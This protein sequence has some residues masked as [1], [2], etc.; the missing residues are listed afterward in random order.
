MNDEEGDVL[1]QDDIDSL[2]HQSESPTGLLGKI[3]RSDGTCTRD[4][5]DIKIE[6]YDFRNPVF[7]TEN[8]LRQIRIRHEK[9]IHFLVARMSLF[10]RMDFNMKMSKLYTTSYQKFTEKMPNPTHI[11]LFKLSKL[12]GI[13]IFNVSPRLA[14]T[15][16]N[17]M[18]GGSGHSV[19]DERYLTEIEATLVD[20]IASIVL[21]EWTKQWEGYQQLD[22]SLVGRENN[23]RF[24]QTSPQDAVMLVVDVEA[25]IGDCMEQFQIAVPY[26]MIEPIVRSIQEDSNKYSSIGA[27]KKRASWVGAYDGI[28][29]PVSAEWSGFELAVED[30][31]ALRPGDTLAL[32]KSLIKRTQLR[33]RDTVAFE[34]EAGVQNG[35]VVV[36][37]L[38]K[39]EEI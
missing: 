8:E 5:G 2:I 25:S 6:V 36:Q 35:N 29:L 12:T 26:F 39:I 33:V 38:K 19:Q 27:K 9:F 10:L 34:G 18:L 17:R 13:G 15:M 1:S 28:G 7:L 24:L 4:K 30:I 31:L 3:Y 11:C 20:D 16:V 21:D 23:G 37:I 14:M 32:P 22:V